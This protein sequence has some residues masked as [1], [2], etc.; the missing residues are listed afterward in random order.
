MNANLQQKLNEA[1]DM[2]D[3]KFQEL[4]GS[5]G[6]VLQSIRKINTKLQSMSVSTQKVEVKK[7]PVVLMEDN[8]TMAKR[9]LMVTKQLCPT[10][11]NVQKLEQTAQLEDK[12][13]STL[14]KLKE[15]LIRKSRE[16]LTNS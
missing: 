10:G 14:C 5:I 1:K 4:E 9:A 2:S 11:M 7:A 6:L 13:M 12:D 15:T 3:Q 8:L 16:Y